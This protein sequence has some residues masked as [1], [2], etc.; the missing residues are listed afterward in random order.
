VKYAIVIISLTILFLSPGFANRGMMPFNPYVKIFEPN[1]R[2]M[3]AWNGTDQI[4]LLSTDLQATDTTGVLEVM[5]LPSEP[6]VK[7][8]D[9]ETFRKAT[10]L[11]NRK[12]YAGQA[13]KGRALS[14]GVVVPS[15]E[16]TFHKK[17]GA[18]DISV[19]HLLDAAGFV[20]WVVEYLGTLGV[21]QDIVSPEMRSLIEEY[22]A[23]DF[24][25]FVFDVISLA[26]E[27]VTNEP[28]QYR[29]KSNHLFYPLKITSTAQG[30][31]SIELL[32]LTPR[33]LNRFPSLPIDRIHLKHDPIEIS[34]DELRA[35][36]EDM[37]SLLK[38][39]DRMK[40]R[41]WEIQGELKEF[42]A[43]LLAR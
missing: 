25:W 14:E 13:G 33:L 9:L 17:I 22:I 1:Q 2:A 26:E 39:Y 12:L 16:V 36:N 27:V 37:Y 4:L 23:D 32:I 40:L 35:L 29:F 21:E 20:D 7:K 24:T 11:I 28:I 31:T 42:G 34:Q 10:D 38:G 30:S 15:G 8:G 19:T 5:P 6:E 18:H 41:I 3:I 43:D